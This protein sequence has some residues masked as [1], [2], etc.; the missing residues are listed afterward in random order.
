MSELLFILHILFTCFHL[1][2]SFPGEAEYTMENRQS[3]AQLSK[4]FRR[5]FEQEKTL[6]TQVFEKLNHT[7]QSQ[8]IKL[9]KLD[10]AVDN[11]TT[12]FDNSK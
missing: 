9:Q 11:L 8:K 7:L 12:G 6:R 10:E 3:M 2:P 5:A 1:G 4:I